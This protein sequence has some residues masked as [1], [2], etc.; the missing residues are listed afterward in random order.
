MYIELQ[1][2]NQF[3]FIYNSTFLKT[4]QELKYMILLRVIE[5]KV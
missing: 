4:S 5:G 3:N 2:I 1:F